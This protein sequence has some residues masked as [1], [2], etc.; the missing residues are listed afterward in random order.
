MEVDRLLRGGIMVDL[1]RAVRQ[2]IR[3]SVESYSIKKLEQFYGFKR[4]VDLRDAGSSIVAFEAWLETGGSD[5]DGPGDATALDRIERYNRDDCVSNLELRDWLERLR[6]ELQGRLGEEPLPRPQPREDDPTPNLSERLAAVEAVA[7]RLASDVPADPADRSEEQHARWLLA[8]L[9]SWHRREDKSFWWRYFHLMDELT[10]GER[11]EEPE[12][13]AGLTYEG[14]VGEVAR[15]YIHRYRFPVQEHD[16]DLGTNVRDPATHGSPGEVVG[17]DEARGTVDL[18][19]GKTSE[20]PHPTSLVPH[21]HYD[22]KVMESA[23]LRIAD[24]AATDGIEAAGVH[25]PARELLLRRPPRLG[26]GDGEPLA[27]A[28]ETGLEAGRRLIGSL[29]GSVLALQG[30]PGSGKTYT[31]ARMILELV[32][33]GKRVGVTATSH[34]VIGNLLDEV[35]KAAALE[36]AS[37]AI[38]QKPQGSEPCT[39]SFATP[40]DSNDAVA[41][42]LASGRAQVA[43]ATIWLWS[44]EE[45][46][47]TLDVLFIDEAGQMSL[48]NAI[49][50]SQAARSLVLLGDPQQLDQPLQGVHPQGAERSAL[51]HLLGEHA[52]MPPALGLFLERTWRL[53]PDLCRFTSDAF[54]E[55]RLE[56]EEHLG[57]QALEADGPVSGTGV[58]F[59]PV[60]HEGNVNESLEEARVVA[61]LVRSL[62][63]G[64]ARW[65]DQHG[66]SRPMTLADI[67]VV[68]PYNAQVQAIARLLPHGAR[69]GTVD[70]FQGQE[71]AVSIYSMATSSPEA[72]P[73]GM[74]FLYSL[75]RLNVASSRA[76]CLAIVVANP[77]LVRVRCKTPRQMRL[78]NALC[79]LVQD[80]TVIDPTSLAPTAEL[81]LTLPLAETAV[82]AS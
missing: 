47:G 67:L 64:G 46:A 61:E 44:R 76:R 39:S 79:R 6:A 38:V 8:Q 32:R 11:L 50:A 12:P 10:D 75:N 62:V 58:R 41:E 19:R 25:S 14:I 48:A 28:G 24:A 34:K 69:V 52:T 26:Q 40:A 35:G 13:L 45:I 18:K 42:A 55:S 65:T 60:E 1:H 53:H 77:A 9:L 21:T 37:V 15:S 49:A 57:V 73:R 16:V 2:G 29:D 22:A 30:P 56:P 54:Y 82:A 4:E 27:R 51:G 17:V 66:I 36:R 7:T 74:E 59:V 72:A 3:A 31:A 71:A 63:E 23:L 43:G 80:A 20:V 70:K 33:A 68:A 78:A 5:V 81:Q